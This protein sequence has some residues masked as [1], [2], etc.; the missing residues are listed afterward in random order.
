MGTFLG[1]LEMAN[2]FISFYTYTT[3]RLK[4]NQK[5]PFKNIA[6]EA[7]KYGKVELF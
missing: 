1:A 6:S 5:S 3:Q 4:I 2:L 7:S